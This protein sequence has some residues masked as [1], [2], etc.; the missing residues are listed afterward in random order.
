M[1][2]GKKKRKIDCI[3]IV[4]DEPL[5]AFDNEQRLERLGYRVVGTRDNFADAMRDLES[6]DVDLVLADINL[7]SEQS[8]IDVA[9]EAAQRDI[10]VLFATGNPPGECAAYA[11]GSLLKPYDD[12][13]LKEALK[14]VD[15]RLQGEEVEAPRGLTWYGDAAL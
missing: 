4:E 7:A 5:T 13:Q 8:G 11:L 2:F 10:P 14:A 9:R 3:L 15:A 6:E 1:L 12:K